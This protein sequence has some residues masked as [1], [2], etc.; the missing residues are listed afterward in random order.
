M[1]S[2]D[3]FE[4]DIRR[5]F[6][7]FNRKANDDQIDMYYDKLKF[8]PNEA[9]DDIIDTITDNQKAMPTP[10]DFKDR[11]EEWRG[12]HKDKSVNEFGET[13]CHECNGHGFYPFWYIPDDMFGKHADWENPLHIYEAV[14]RCPRCENW[15][16]TLNCGCIMKT[17]AE[18][19]EMGYRLEE[20]DCLKVKLT[21]IPM[22]DDIPF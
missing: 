12:G 22:D 3:V 15:K 1:P 11:W 8:I 14:S 4:R 9:W 5:I 16:R 20:P 2:L 18:L 19:T 6:R 13:Y 17:K 7:F 21:I 10:R